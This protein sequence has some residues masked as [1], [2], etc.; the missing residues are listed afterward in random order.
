VVHRG[1]HAV[2]RDVEA[3]VAA[4]VGVVVRRLAGERADV[5]ATCG[6]CELGWLSLARDRAKRER[7]G[8]PVD[9]ETWNEIRAA[10]AKLKVPA[11]KIEALAGVAP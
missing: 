2:R 9:E 7:E 6:R 4:A 3:A 10:A 8:I 1:D 11:E 5:T